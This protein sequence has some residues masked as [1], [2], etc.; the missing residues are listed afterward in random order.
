MSEGWGKLPAVALQTRRRSRRFALPVAFAAATLAFAT[1]CAKKPTMKLNHA[2]VSGVQVGFP[3]SLGVLMTVVVDVYNPNGYD[4][5]VRAMRGQVVFADKYTL[6]VEFQAPPDGVWLASD[7]TTPVR[8]PVS[9]PVPLA[10]QLLREVYTTPTI[11]FRIQGRADVTA[12]RTFKIEKDNYEVDEPG[13][14]SR[15]QV[16]AA[17]QGAFFP[18]PPR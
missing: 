9:L 6:P 13:M 1:G 4:V 3:P 11:P 10:L 14:I 18:G 5:A 15:Q 16:E 2:E 12:S 17:V 8:V 7:T